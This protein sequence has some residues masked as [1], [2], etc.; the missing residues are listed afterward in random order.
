MARAGLIA[1]ELDHPHLVLCVAP[2]QHELDYTAGLLRSAG[3]EY[4]VFNESDLDDQITSLCTQPLDR[5]Q[6]PKRLRKHLRGLTLLGT[7]P[8]KE[9]THVV[10]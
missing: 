2:D 4:R 8:K 3:L 9:T 1:P 10:N 5:D 6:L 7:E